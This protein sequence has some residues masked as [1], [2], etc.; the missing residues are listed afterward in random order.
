LSGMANNLDESETY[1]QE[2]V[3]IAR[4]LGNKRDIAIRVNNI[5]EVRK[6]RGDFDGAIPFYK[7]ALD[8]FRQIGHRDNELATLNNLGVVYVELQDYKTAESY[9]RQVTNLAGSKDWWVLYETYLYLAQACFAQ[10]NLAEA[11]IAAQRALEEG[12]KNEDKAVT[13]KAWSI[14]AQISS[15][16]GMYMDI[17]GKPVTA[18]ECYDRSLACFADNDPERGRVLELW[19]KYEYESDN[20]AKAKDLINDALSLYKSLSLQAEVDRVLTNWG[21]V[22]G[23]D[24]PAQH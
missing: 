16:L 17:G 15:R 12:I 13:G 4:E 23:W 6:L 5:G 18:S 22:F 2:A 7:E 20:D 11:T 24:A 21:A 9:L 19:G 1:M 14:L 8:G 10:A 3:E